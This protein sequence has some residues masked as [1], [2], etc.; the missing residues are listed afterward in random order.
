MTLPPSP[1]PPKVL[2]DREG[3]REGGDVG[4]FESNME[5]RESERREKENAGY[6]RAPS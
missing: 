1:P 3:G 4:C 2:P 6:P 5:E